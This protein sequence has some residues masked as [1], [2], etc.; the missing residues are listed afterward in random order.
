MEIRHLLIVP[1]SIYY[2]LDEDKVVIIG[3]AYVKQSPRVVT[4]M[5]K[6]F[7]EHYDS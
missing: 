2:L 5:I 7:L 4:S 3:I 6:R 1:N